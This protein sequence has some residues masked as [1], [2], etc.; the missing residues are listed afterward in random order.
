MTSTDP[1]ISV[2]IVTYIFSVGTLTLGERTGIWSIN[3][4]CNLFQKVLFQNNR[5]RKPK[6]IQTQSHSENDQ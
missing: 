2:K 3:N 4:L 6:E 1:V 5:G